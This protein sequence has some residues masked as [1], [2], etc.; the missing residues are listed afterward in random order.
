M[1][2]SKII[3]GIAIFCIALVGL[4]IAGIGD[5]WQRKAA[6]KAEQEAAAKAEQEREA[7]ERAAQWERDAPKRAEQERKERVAREMQAAQERDAT[8]R[9]ERERNAAALKEAGE[10]GVLAYQRRDYREAIKWLQ[11]V[12]EQGDGDASLIVGVCY[13]ELGNLSEAK[14]WWQRGAEQG[15]DQAQYMHA[16][17]LLNL[18]VDRRDATLMIEGRSWVQRSARQ[19]NQKAVRL[20]RELERAENNP[21]DISLALKRAGVI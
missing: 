1:E 21:V 2:N 20:A 7:A 11:I 14:R 13:G 4:V 9:A 6:V 3:I 8:A 15:N 12:A 10:Q 19:G 18:G 16:L 17:T 5:S